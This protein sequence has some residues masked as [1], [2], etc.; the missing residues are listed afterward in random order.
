MN[1]NLIITKRAED[2]LDNILYN[3]INQS[4]NIQT[5]ELMMNEL[6]HVYDNLEYNPK[7][8]TFSKDAFLKSRGYRKAVV[9]HYEYIIIFRIEEE[10]KRVYIVGFFR[11]LE[12]YKNKL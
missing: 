7:M 10:S 4:K 5:P 12:L 9:L 1:Y 8:Y 6:M 3:I 11:N 2:L